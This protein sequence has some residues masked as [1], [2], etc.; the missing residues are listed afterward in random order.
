MQNNQDI[1]KIV[2]I[3]NEVLVGCKNGN[4][5]LIR[6]SGGITFLGHSGEIT[7]FA[8]LPNKKFISSSKDGDFRIWNMTSV[9]CERILE[10]GS[11]D[12]SECDAIAV[13]PDG[14]VAISG[15]CSPAWGCFDVFDTITGHCLFKK[16]G[17]VHRPE[18]MLV[19]VAK[20]YLVV[21]PCCHGSLSIWMV[22]RHVCVPVNARDN[23]RIYSMAISSNGEII[24]GSDSL[25]IFTLS[26][27]GNI[28]NSVTLNNFNVIDYIIPI[29]S[30]KL[31]IVDRQG[32][33]VGT[34]KLCDYLKGSI[35]YLSDCDS[36][37]DS[38]YI[39]LPRLNTILSIGSDG[40]KINTKRLGST[41]PVSKDI[42]EIRKNSRLLSQAIRTGNLFFGQ[43]P[44]EVNI[45]IAALTGNR[46]DQKEAEK[47]ARDH[48]CKPC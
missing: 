22:N 20:T 12:A 35:T 26:D 14:L 40:K 44:K 2:A 30:Y 31:L 7:N 19:G 34:I 18:G 3:G 28:E 33:N 10:K 38:S 32:F 41:E 17:C 42:V 27:I 5:I 15:N 8:L 47:V 37:Y 36:Q 1:T 21:H 24:T 9:S 29:D 6:E 48:F 16:Q 39:F 11:I 43:L 25:N 45:Q 46:E 23:D 4:I 13:L